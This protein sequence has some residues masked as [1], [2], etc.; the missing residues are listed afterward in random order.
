MLPLLQ[1]LSQFIHACI[2][3]RTVTAFRSPSCA[4]LLCPEPTL[5]NVM[6]VFVCRR[7][8]H[9]IVRVRLEG[10]EQFRVEGVRVPYAQKKKKPPQKKDDAQKTAADKAGAADDSATEEQEQEQEKPA[11][12]LK[13]SKS[14]KSVKAAGGPV[15][16][17]KAAAAAALAAKGKDKDKVC[18]CVQWRD[19][20]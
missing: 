14:D 10:E 3:R 8:G 1:P 13:R 19:V 17:V 18:V 12:E 16:A 15:R 9:W 11:A 6:C 5:P 4:S 2:A 20:V 7:R